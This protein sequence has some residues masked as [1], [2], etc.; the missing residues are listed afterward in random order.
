MLFDVVRMPLNLKMW[1]KVEG[2]VDR[3]QKWQNGYSFVGLLGFVL[4]KKL[5]VLKVDLKKWNKEE[6]GDLVLER[7]IC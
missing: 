7:K 6:F 3:V 5:R 4:A 1:L 2:F